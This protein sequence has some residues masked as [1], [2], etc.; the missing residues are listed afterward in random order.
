[1]AEF[2]VVWWIVIF[3]FAILSL[4]IISNEINIYR[5]SKRQKSKSIKRRKPVSVKINHPSPEFAKLISNRNEMNGLIF[6]SKGSFIIFD[7]EA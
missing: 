4:L 1:M 6:N 2:L 7:K 3:I 5:K